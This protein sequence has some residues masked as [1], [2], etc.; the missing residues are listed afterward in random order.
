MAETLGANPKD[1]R[2]HTSREA[3][4]TVHRFLKGQ[5]RS[6]MPSRVPGTQREPI[7]G[8][9][10]EPIIGTHKDS[11]LTFPVAALGPH[12]DAVSSPTD[13]AAEEKHSVNYTN[14]GDPAEIPSPA[15][16]DTAALRS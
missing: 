4:D 10:R 6:Q 9:Q 2:H 13:G 14:E 1:G 16:C 7:I 15:S 8:T 11:G 3:P 5:G 12:P